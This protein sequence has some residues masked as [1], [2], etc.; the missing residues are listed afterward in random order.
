VCLPPVFGSTGGVDEANN[1]GQARVTKTTA[2]HISRR[3]QK[4]EKRVLHFRQGLASNLHFRQWEVPKCNTA[5]QIEA[6]NR[7]IFVYLR[8]VIGSSGGKELVQVTVIRSVPIRPGTE[9]RDF[10]A[11]LGRNGNGRLFRE[12]T[13]FR[14]FCGIA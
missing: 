3:E 1:E 13:A 10:G 4:R 6:R 2:G 14:K 5:R 8:Q 9:W 7:W 11:L 12:S